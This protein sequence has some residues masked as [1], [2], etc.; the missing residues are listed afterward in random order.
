MVEDVLRVLRNRDGNRI[1]LHQVQCRMTNESWIYDNAWKH[2]RSQRS[3]P[4]AI[5][6]V[7]VRIRVTLVVDAMWECLSKIE[8]VYGSE[9]LIM[10]CCEIN[11][12]CA[13]RTL[14]Y[15]TFVHVLFVD[16]WFHFVAPAPCSKQHSFNKSIWNS[17]LIKRMAEDI[18]RSPAG[19]ISGD[20]LVRG[21]VFL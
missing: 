20:R 12:G 1:A 3:G 2:D 17:S 16:P 18:G 11:R 7:V 13:I 5:V 10:L 19:T 9:L 4:G 14:S 15:K 21:G 8:D 6:K